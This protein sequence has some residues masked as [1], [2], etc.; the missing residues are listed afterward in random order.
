MAIGLSKYVSEPEPTA[1][2]EA[3][4]AGYVQH[5]RLNSAEAQAM[6][7]LLKLRILSNAVYF[8][9]RA[10]AGEDSMERL[11]GRAETYAQR[12]RW[13]DAHGDAIRTMLQSKVNER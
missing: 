1:A 9:G 7:D 13:I 12:L 5:G 2:C 8:V 6:P 10:L 11:A 4:A 3:F